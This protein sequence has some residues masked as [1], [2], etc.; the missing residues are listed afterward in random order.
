MGD[1]KLL[2]PGDLRK[3][4]W[5]VRP[6]ALDTAQRMVER[7]HYAHG[8][9][10][11]AVACHG[12][13]HRERSFWDADCYGVAWWL[14]PTRAAAVATHPDNPG[15]VLALT[16]LVIHPGAPRNAATFL[17]ARS[18]K[19]LDAR[20]DCLVTYADTWRGH[21]G[22]IYRAANWT[23]VG[24]TDPEW[25]YVRNGR[26][27]GPKRGPVTLSRAQM[28]ADGFDALGKFAKH[29]FVLARV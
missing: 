7:Y 13:F 29:K 17:L 14:P 2:S 23:Y 11:T 28:E 1:I 18:V 22:G 21:T 15:G 20:W 8:G 5:L 4:S 10:N 9:S 19:L 26:M 12:L 16:R 24:L 25:V 6:V 3:A 27:M